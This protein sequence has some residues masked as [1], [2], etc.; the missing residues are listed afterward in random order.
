MKPAGVLLTVTDC[1]VVSSAG[2]RTMVLPPLMA[3]GTVCD[4][5]IL[6]ARRLFEASRADTVTSSFVPV[7][8]L[9]LNEVWVDANPKPPPLPPTTTLVAP[10]I[11]EAST[12]PVALP[13]GGVAEQLTVY[14]VASRVVASMTDSKLSVKP[15]TLKVGQ[16]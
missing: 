15:T 16:T 13:V 5:R 12:L 1:I 8:R 6:I 10:G 7:G 14:A 3:P 2:P 9:T 11:A 4:R